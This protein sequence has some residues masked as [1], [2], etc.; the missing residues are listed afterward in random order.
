VV[1]SGL[2]AGQLV[3][4]DGQMTLKPGSVVTMQAPAATQAPAGKP[5]A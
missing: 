4:T 1:Q 2:K 3:V 5:A